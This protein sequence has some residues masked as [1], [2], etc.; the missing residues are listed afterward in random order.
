M[1]KKNVSEY[2]KINSKIVKITNVVLLNWDV[3]YIKFSG[4]KTN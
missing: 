1:Y 3:L 2:D 4:I